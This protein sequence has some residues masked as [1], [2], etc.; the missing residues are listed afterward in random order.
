MLTTILTFAGIAVFA[1][2]WIVA[3]AGAVD[4][5][6][7]IRRYLSARGPFRPQPAPLTRIY[8]QKPLPRP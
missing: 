6:P 4:A 2:L 3:L 1:V 8:A 5:L 7:P